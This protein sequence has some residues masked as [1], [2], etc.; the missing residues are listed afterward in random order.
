[1]CK[2]VEEDPTV[3]VTLSE[4]YK[5]SKNNFQYFLHTGYTIENAGETIPPAFF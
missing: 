5:Q 1:M 2:Y 4:S 3:Q